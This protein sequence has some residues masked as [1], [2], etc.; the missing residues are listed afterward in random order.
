M[1]LSKNPENWLFAALVIIFLVF[2]LIIYKHHQEDAD[3]QQRID[4]HSEIVYNMQIAKH[5]KYLSG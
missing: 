5:V 2:V 4:D 3:L 1:T